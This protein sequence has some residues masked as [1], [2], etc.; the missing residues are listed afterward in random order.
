MR[1]QIKRCSWIISASFALSILLTSCLR[2]EWR[3]EIFLGKA[4][5]SESDLNV[6]QPS[7]QNDLSFHRIEYDDRSFH[8]PLYYGLRTAYFPA[9]FSNLG[10]EAEFIHAKIYSKSEQMVYVSGIMEGEPI[11]SII[12]FGE[13]V[14]GFSMTHGLNFLFFNLVGR[15][16]IVSVIDRSASGGKDKNDEQDKVV[17]YGRLGIGP[18]IPHT[19]SVVDGHGREQYELHGPAYQIATGMEINIWRKLFLLLEY[20]YTLVKVNEAKIALGHASTELNTNHWVFG[21]STTL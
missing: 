9:S 5:T 15:L 20:K 18:L 10:L 19:E 4:S 14:Q 21:L 11:D 3:F 1:Y 12:R 2:A 17:L 16:P 13:M 8:T 7:K 6:E